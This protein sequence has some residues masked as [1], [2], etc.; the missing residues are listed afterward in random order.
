M[1]SLN[2]SR[3]TNCAQVDRYISILENEIERAKFFKENLM[4]Y[5]N[6]FFLV[7]NEEKVVKPFVECSQCQNKVYADDFGD[8]LLSGQ[9]IFCHPRCKMEW[10]EPCDDGF[11]HDSEF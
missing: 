1:L 6:E 5:K 8:A 2:F 7:E 3:M 9:K 11:I 10:D 4:S